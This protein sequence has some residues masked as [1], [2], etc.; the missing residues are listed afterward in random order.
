MKM[1]ERDSYDER[2]DHAISALS[3]GS[4]FD[5]KDEFLGTVLRYCSAVNRSFMVKR[6]NASKVNHI[7]DRCLSCCEFFLCF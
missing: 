4:L 1:D 6:S 5:S 3:K 7:I 2:Y